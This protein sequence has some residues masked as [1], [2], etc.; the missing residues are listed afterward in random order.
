MGI[1]GTFRTTGIDVLPGFFETLRHFLGKP[2]P[3]SSLNCS[4]TAVTRLYLDVH[5][6]NNSQVFRKIADLKSLAT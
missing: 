6:R 5:I 1:L 4:C 3:S 2:S